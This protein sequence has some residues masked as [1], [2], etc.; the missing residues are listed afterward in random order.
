MA[1]T[2]LTPEQKVELKMLREYYDS[3]MVFHFPEYNVCI[4]I[5][6]TP[7]HTCGKFAAAIMS[8]GEEKYRKKVGEYLVRNAFDLGAFTNFGKPHNFAISD[9]AEVLASAVSPIA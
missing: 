3:L 5:D 7:G 2:K 6:Y 1:N 4:G 9:M 8:P